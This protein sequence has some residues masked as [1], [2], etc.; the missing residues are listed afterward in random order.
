[1]KLLRRYLPNLERGD[2]FDAVTFGDLAAASILRKR[3]G[4]YFM[5]RAT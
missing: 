5:E 1:M 3:A 4:K 2:K